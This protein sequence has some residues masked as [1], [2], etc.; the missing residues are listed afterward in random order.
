MEGEERDEKGEE[1]SKK[2]EGRGE[3]AIECCVRCRKVP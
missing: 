3:E 1:R 2:G